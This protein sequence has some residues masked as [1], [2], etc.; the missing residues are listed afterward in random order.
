MSD[1]RRVRLRTSS[2]AAKSLA[3]Y[4]EMRNSDDIA[5]AMIIAEKHDGTWVIVGQG[6]SPAAMG[7]ALMT[8]AQAVE[9]ATLQ[10][11]EVRLTPHVEPERRGVRSGEKALPRL[12]TKNKDGVLVPP[13]GE[14]FVSCGECHHPH[15]FMLHR[16]DDD[17]IAR[18]A[19]TH[20]GNELE[21]APAPDRVMEFAAA[22]LGDYVGSLLEDPS[23]LVHP[24]STISPSHA[25]SEMRL[26][27]R[28]L[29]IDFESLLAKGSHFQ[30][31]RLANLERGN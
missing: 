4:E 27:A 7:I 15:W 18:F 28:D 11:R 16:N 29:G 5:Q 21:A 24:D 3:Q 8:A 6:M 26:V 9:Q 1:E 20:C 2:D 31:H 10:G 13:A 12:I 30:R 23:E 17:S 14:N 22:A 19:C 25:L